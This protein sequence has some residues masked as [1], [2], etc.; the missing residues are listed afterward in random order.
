M[1]PL[2]AVRGMP[3]RLGDE[4]ARLDH[5]IDVFRDVTRRFAF[6]R[7][8][9]PVV[10]QTPV[11]ARSLGETTDV[12][13]KEMYSFIDRSGDSLTLRPEFTAGICR[14]FLTNGWQ[15]HLPLKLATWGPLFRHERPQKGRYRQFHQVDVEVLGV[16]EPSADV[17]LVILA[18]LFLQ[19][20]GVASAVRLELNT[21]GDA[22]SRAR[23][24][25]ALVDHFAAHRHALS[26]DSRRRLET[27]P[28]RILDS[29]DP[30]DQAAIATAPTID[31]FLSASARDFFRQVEEGLTAAGV[32][33]VRNP[34]LV[35]GFDYYRHTAFEFV[36]DRLGAQGTVI[37]GG[38]YDGLVEAMGGPAT[39]AVGW[40][41]G[42]ERLME[43]MA[44]PA[45][46][47][48]ALAVIPETPEAEAEAWRITLALRRAGE[49]VDMAHRGTE[50]RRRE[51]AGRA[52]ARELLFVGPEAG[53]GWRLN[54]VG[55][56][57][58]DE[59]I[60][61]RIASLRRA[62]PGSPPILWRGQPA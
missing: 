44:E 18:D 56:G 37:G 29:K 12:V 8:D 58:A 21:L 27:N 59:A 42:V 23:W 52:G 17:E 15:Q 36:T 38:R 35:R 30:A 14:A 25:A 22:D 49:A 47:A 62:L 33:Y 28:L 41:G 43:L 10:E 50:K 54:L 45:F 26:A 60:R 6:R 24:R 7:V 13:A 55:Q 48:P 34:R 46:M 1:E 3:D 31:P 2:K 51:L 61:A 16:A 4:A 39:P 9:V 32:A 53:G 40:A 19:E 20:L 11:F 57:E 5:V